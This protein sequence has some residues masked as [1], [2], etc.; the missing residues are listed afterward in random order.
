MQGGV[1]LVGVAHHARCGERHAP[2]HLSVNPALVVQVRQRG[3]VSHGKHADTAPLE[4]GAGGHQR[5]GFVRRQKNVDPVSDG[6]IHTPPD[7]VVAAQVSG[8][9]R[10]FI[11]SGITDEVRVF[12]AAQQRET[13]LGVSVA[14]QFQN[15]VDQGKVAVEPDAHGASR[16]S[17][18]RG[19]CTHN[20]PT[21]Q[22]AATALEKPTWRPRVRRDGR[23]NKPLYRCGSMCGSRSWKVRPEQFSPIACI[24]H[25]A[26]W[27]Y[28]L[29]MIWAVCV[30]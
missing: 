27:R 14:D 28:T 24:F 19:A 12:V 9:D 15:P 22:P 25:S 16:R 29:A 6:K 10:M 3:R 18:R 11:G 5:D 2:G 21:A 1:E 17:M 7:V 26:P 13:A 4:L 30:P 23:S 8:L 20:E